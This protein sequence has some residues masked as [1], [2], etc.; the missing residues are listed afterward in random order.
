MYQQSTKTLFVNELMKVKKE[1]FLIA[2]D[3]IVEQQI[4]IGKSWV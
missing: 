4:Q 3:V 2:I 1:S